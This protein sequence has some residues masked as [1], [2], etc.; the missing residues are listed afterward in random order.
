MT[1]FFNNKIFIEFINNNLGIDI[2]FGTFKEKL[3]QID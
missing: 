2:K 1:Q 3:F